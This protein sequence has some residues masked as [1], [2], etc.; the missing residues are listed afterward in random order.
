MKHPLSTFTNIAYIIAGTAIIMAG[1]DWL[2]D[3]AGGFVIALGVLSAVYHAT[4]W[5]WARKG[6]IIAIFATF[7]MVAAW[8]LAQFPGFEGYRDVLFV[9]A[10]LTSLMVGLTYRK[11][12]HEQI[13]ALGMFNAFLLAM[14]SFLQFVPAMVFILVALWMGQRAEQND[15]DLADYDR[16]HGLW[17]LLT[18]ISILLLGI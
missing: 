5:Y 11:W 9:W 1:G 2:Q 12:N 14:R 4:E 16:P 3:V 7:N 10:L 8:Q 13:G 17:H 15:K 6:D 18:A